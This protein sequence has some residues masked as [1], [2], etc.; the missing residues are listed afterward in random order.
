MNDPDFCMGFALGFLV[1]GA[2]GFIL[3][4]ISLA[5]LRAR[6]AGTKQQIVGETRLTPRQAVRQS[7]AAQLEIL[8]W[9]VVMLA[10]G[11]V[12]LFVLLR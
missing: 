9:V 7:T 10:I 3:Q 1:A 6:Q 12:L 4:R 2:F 5:T 11:G 8:L